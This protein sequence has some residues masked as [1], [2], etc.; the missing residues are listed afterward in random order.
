MYDEHWSEDR[1]IQNLLLGPTPEEESHLRDCPACAQRWQQAQS[2]RAALLAA[3]P[4]VSEYRLSKQRR[5]IQDR[6]MQPPPGRRRYIPALAAAALALLF[7]IVL[8]RPAP[9]EEVEDTSDTAVFEDVF[10][11]SS[12]AE[13]TSVE[14]VKSLFEVP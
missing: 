10:A 12:S 9:K 4:E 6:L 1:I 5:A 11:V 13:P 8:Y 14:P 2:R 7:L 3:E